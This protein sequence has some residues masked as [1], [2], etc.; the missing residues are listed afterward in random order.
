MTVWSP[1]DAL[2][3]YELVAPLGAGGMGEVWKARD[4][5]VDRVV[6]IK[7]LRPEH[8]ERFKREARAI[9]AL[10]HPHICQLYDVGQDYLVME[11]VEGDVLRGP[12]PV[13]E[14]LPSGLADRGR[15][16]GGTSEGDRASRSQ[17]GQRPGWRNRSK[18]ARLRPGAN[19]RVGSC[20]ATQE[21]VSGTLS[22]R[23]IIAGTVA[24]MSPEQAQG[25]P[26]DARSDVFSFGAGTVRIVE[27]APG[28]CRARRRLPLLSAVVRDEPPQLEGARVP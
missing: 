10:S 23:G 28:L 2:G 27:W 13:A 1:G 12:L 24:Y 8:A 5:R 9:A 22:E 3:P 11:Y 6:A 4:P 26:V 15:I 7:R 25:Q 21:T 14:A 19:G 20:P 18:A 16:G 17:A